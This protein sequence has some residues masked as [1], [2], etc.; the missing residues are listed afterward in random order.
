VAF[1]CP[2]PRQRRTAHRSSSFDKNLALAS[3]DDATVAV[4]AA[5]LDDAL[6]LTSDERTVVN[7][8][9]VCSPSVVYVTSVLKLVG[10]SNDNN[11]RSRRW[12]RRRSKR[13]APNDGDTDDSQQLKQ[14]LPRGTALGSGSGFVVDSEG[15]I[16]TNYHVIQR[17]Y[18]TNQAMMRYDSFWDGLAKNTTNKMKSF[19]GD[20]EMMDTLESFVNETVS[21]ISGRDSLVDSSARDSSGL[22]AQVFVRFGTNG[23]GD[24][25]TGGSGSA[26]YHPCEIVDVVK[27]LD[28]AVLK[29]ND[30]LP[31]LKALNYGSSSDLLVGQSLLAIGNPFGLDRTITSGLVSALGRSVTGVAGN[32]IKNCI[33]TDAAINPGNSGGPLL[34]LD[35][36][37]VGVNTMIISTSGSSAG[38][39]FAVPGDNVK[40]STDNIV[41]LDKQRQ[42]RNAKRKGRGWLGVDVAKASLEESLKK[43]F[44]ARGDKGDIGAFVTSIAADS[45]LYKDQDESGTSIGITTITDG[46]IH[47]GDRIINV[48]GNAIANGGDFITDMKQRV[49]GEQ[50]TLTVQDVKGE[51]RVVYVTLGRIPL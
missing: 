31:S 20:S 43:R 26:S 42:L 9:R 17:A 32:D 14:K 2:A 22:P 7:V 45:P 33:Q 36:N 28:V 37:V 3:S 16:V 47:L 23:D 13:E 4:K 46:N 25:S 5:D 51:K 8:H 34:N 38:I 50:L 35:G 11:S 29:I 12:Q 44:T 21:A 1:H 30:K 18:E 41:E 6:G 40:E 15:Y 24:G 10:D 48:G 19:S 39:G 49:E 27:E